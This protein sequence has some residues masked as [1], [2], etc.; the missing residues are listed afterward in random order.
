MSRILEGEN[1]VSTI[2]RKPWY[3]L[4]EPKWNPDGSGWI[5]TARVTA[6]RKMASQAQ[7]HKGRT[8]RAHT[9]TLEISEVDS[10]SEIFQY[11]LLCLTDS[12]D[13]VILIEKEI[14]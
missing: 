14:V 10:A 4:E 1:S 7:E 8:A 5:A 6:S 2:R 12:K 3:K 9:I 11:L 13:V